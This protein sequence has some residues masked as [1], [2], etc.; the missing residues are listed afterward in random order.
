MQMDIQCRS[1]DLTDGLRDYVRKRL[2]YSLNCGDG[3]IVRVVVRLSDINGPRG[4]E[5]KRCHLELRLKGLPEVVIE[6]TEADLYVAIDRAAER[7]GRALQRCLVRQ[8]EFAPIM[9]LNESTDQS[10]EL[11]TERT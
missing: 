8:R 3:H 7:A 10:D 1:F 9:R 4:G 11:K 5:D 6:D 2:A